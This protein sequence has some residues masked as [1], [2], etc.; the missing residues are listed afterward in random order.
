MNLIPKQ[1]LIEGVMS[2]TCIVNHFFAL[3]P[4]NGK[5]KNEQEVLAH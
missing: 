1:N 5:K 4:S 3:F 2:V